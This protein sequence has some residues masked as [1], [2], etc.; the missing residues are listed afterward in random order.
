MLVYIIYKN[1]T[2]AISATLRL[3]GTRVPITRASKSA[4]QWE[5]GTPVVCF[6]PDAGSSTPG[7]L[8]QPCHR[9]TAAALPR[10]DFSCRIGV[11]TARC[12]RPR[13][14]RGSCCC[15]Y[16]ETAINLWL[17]S[18]YVKG[19]RDAGNEHRLLA[20]SGGIPSKATRERA[21]DLTR[22][23]GSNTSPARPLVAHANVT[24]SGI[25]AA[26]Q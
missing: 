19:G 26:L 2:K 15:E 16:R 12:S 4:E 23:S 9:Y 25:P 10:A 24:A 17:V 3:F 20:T 14:I 18:I 22:R 13:P 1:P 11:A 8:Q 7:H 21:T 5:R 6:T